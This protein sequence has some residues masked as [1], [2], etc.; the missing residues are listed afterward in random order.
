MAGESTRR[1]VKNN[2]IQGIYNDRLPV[3]SAHWVP[4]D[5]KTP[6]KTG[7]SYALNARHER[8]TIG[9]AFKRNAVALMSTR[10]PD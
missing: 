10:N 8:K 5:L 6:D 1:I 9:L 4:V 2:R 3:G 7:L